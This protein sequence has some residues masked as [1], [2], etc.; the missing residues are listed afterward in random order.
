MGRR[1]ARGQSKRDNEEGDSGESQGRGKGFQGRKTGPGPGGIGFRKQVSGGTK[2]RTEAPQRGIEP[3]GSYQASRVKKASEQGRG[4]QGTAPEFRFPGRADKG[5]KHPGNRELGKGGQGQRTP[6]RK[7]DGKPIYRG[8]KTERI[9]VE[10]EPEKI[11]RFSDLLI[12]MARKE[13]PTL[14]G[15]STSPEPLAR[16]DYTMELDLK[17]RALQQFWTV[18]GLPDK[19]NRITPSP[20]PR[21]YRTTT[22]RR[23][24]MD[25]GHFHLDFLP[26]PRAGA[27]RLG[28]ASLL[29]PKEHSAIYAFIL[30]KLNQPAYAQIAH[31]L[32]YLV[33]RG[34]YTRFTVLFNVHQLNGNVVRKAKLLSE[35]L[36][37]MDPKTTSAFLFY[38]SGKSPFYL[39]QRSPEGPWKFKKLFGPDNLRLNVG[40]KNY[41]FHPTSFCQVNASILPAFLEKAHQLLKARPEQRLI[42]LYSGFG[43][44]SLGLAGAYKEVIGVDA[45]GMSIQAAQSMASSDKATRCRFVSG[46]IQSR[47]LDRLLP[48]P[49]AVTPEAILLDPPKQGTDPGV[50]RALAERGPMR[51][52]HIFCDMEALPKEVNQWRR[53]GYM[54]AK[55]VPLDMFPGTDNLEVMVLFIPDRYSILNRIDK[56]APEG[57][58]GPII[59]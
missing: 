30:G 8:G 18:N 41:A 22:K 39:D 55:V 48:P 32:N 29:E 2:N 38:D 28:A 6:L 54:I 34:D 23:V 43:L 53:N 36:Q 45:A 9:P 27:E 1:L 26:D 14:V 37:T 16:M 59:R 19:P 5:K 13:A 10:R 17:N 52:L 24:I 58:P 15:P 25:K 49:D 12:Q 46:R 35:H 4:G 51:V 20:K 40:E 21:H 50:I 57:Y 7:L 44:F 42:D 47:T 11:I 56:K 33:I 31:A 3:E